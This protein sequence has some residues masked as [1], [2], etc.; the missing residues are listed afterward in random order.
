MD[1]RLLFRALGLLIASVAMFMLHNV[2]NKNVGRAD[3]SNN[4]RIQQTILS[5]Q[6]K[7]EEVLQKMSDSLVNCAQT[8]TL[9]LINTIGSES[10]YSF[11]LFEKNDLVA[12]YNALLP[13]ANLRPSQLNN[14]IMRTDNGWYFIVKKKVS[15]STS[16]FALFRI[17]SRYPVSN[18][19]LKDELDPS[20]GIDGRTTITIDSKRTENAITDA[21]G[22]Y[23]FSISCENIQILSTWQLVADG[24]VL[25]L[26][27]L[28]IIFAAGTFVVAI[29]KRGIRNRAL[30]VLAIAQVGIYVWTLFLQLSV[31][32]SEWFLFSPQIFA[33]DWWAP[34]LFYLMLATSIYPGQQ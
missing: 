33:Y 31:Q 34:S 13:I 11:Y 10:N 2:I 9:K 22:K 25:L 32:M 20:F 30:I 21:N 28:L 18:D 14:S 23:L 4:T 17:K 3:S 1:R 15:H 6:Q 26:W 19:Y 5:H 24:I 12:W 8:D 7:M 29:R 16:I 27:L